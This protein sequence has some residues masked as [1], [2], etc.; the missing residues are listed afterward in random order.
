MHRRRL[1]VGLV[2]L[3]S[4]R[5]DLDAS[6]KAVEDLCRYREELIERETAFLEEGGFA[7]MAA[8]I[9]FLPFE[10][11]ARAG[12]PAVGISNFTWDWI[13]ESYARS[14]ARW[15]PLVQWIR[16]CYAH[17]DLLLQLPMHGDC[18]AFQRIRQ[19]PLVA[20]HARTGRRETRRRLGIGEGR[21]AYLVS[22]FALDLE[23]GAERLLESIPDA[24]F[25]YKKPLDWTLANGLCLDPFEDLSYVD[26][27]NAVDAVITKPGYGIVADCL[28]HGVPMIYSDR[29][30]F[31]EYP[32]LVKAVEESLPC[33]F[34]PSQELYAGRWERA[35][36]ELS[37]QSSRGTALRSDGGQVCARELLDF[38]ALDAAAAPGPAPSG[39]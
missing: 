13:Y 9:P 23:N 11:A 16:S 15:K 26:V 5:F 27:V 10:A 6:R 22:F 30:E 33:V 34:L 35:I 37:S 21:A 4:I 1:D 20:R 2:Q 25:L 14:D 24:F 3:D 8:D 7:G 36:R 29:G 28:A 39:K 31:P 18:S 12:L 19:V 38:F 17:A 32:L